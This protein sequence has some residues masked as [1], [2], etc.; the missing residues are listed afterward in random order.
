MQAARCTPSQVSIIFLLGPY[1][2]MCEILHALSRNLLEQM[3]WWGW[4]RPCGYHCS[5]SSKLL[6]PRGSEL[7]RLGKCH[8]RGWRATAGTFHKAAGTW[9]CLVTSHW[10][11]DPARS[12]CVPDTLLTPSLLR[13][14]LLHESCCSSFPASPYESLLCNP[15]WVLQLMWTKCS[16]RDSKGFV[17][18]VKGGDVEADSST[19]E[20]KRFLGSCQCVRILKCLRSIGTTV[21]L[22]TVIWPDQNTALFSLGSSK[23]ALTSGKSWFIWGIQPLFFLEETDM[24]GYNWQQLDVFSTNSVIIFLEIERCWK[25]VCRVYLEFLSLDH[26]M[27]FLVLPVIRLLTIIK[28]FLKTSCHNWSCWNSQTCQI[29]S[30]GQD[31]ASGLLRKKSRWVWYLL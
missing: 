8:P 15:V 18:S 10:E 26:G 14:T 31:C 27:L 24:L 21:R 3:S 12:G 9:V 20:V 25:L 7:S 11:M 6:L 23:L 2:P 28:L 4:T 29:L 19:R 17:P 13:K 16:W 5:T 30:L 1:E 22:L